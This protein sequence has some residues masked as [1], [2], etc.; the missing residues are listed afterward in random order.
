MQI[1]VT[2]H[3]HFLNPMGNESSAFQLAIRGCWALRHF[4]VL[5]LLLEPNAVLSVRLQGRAVVSTA[6]SIARTL[7]QF[8]SFRH[9]R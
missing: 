6:L 2:L 1:R 4:L 9:H 8:L 3:M 7:G 5:I